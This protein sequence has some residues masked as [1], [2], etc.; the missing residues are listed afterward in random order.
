MQLFLLF[1][2][3]AFCANV[4]ALCWRW[5]SHRS[6]TAPH[7]Y[8]ASC[9]RICASTETT[10]E[11][12]PTAACERHRVAS[13]E[14]AETES[15]VGRRSKNVLFSLRLVHAWEMALER[16]DQG[17]PDI[18]D[19]GLETLMLAA[20]VNDTPG[21]AH[22]LLRM[23]PE[24]LHMTLDV[25]SIQTRCRRGM[26]LHL[27]S[28]GSICVPLVPWLPPEMHNGTRPGLL[29]L[30][31]RAGAHEVVKCLLSAGV[32]PLPSMD[33]VIGYML[34]N[35]MARTIASHVRCDHASDTVLA[36]RPARYTDILR[37]LLSNHS[38]DERRRYWMDG[39]DSPRHEALDRIN[40]SF[41]RGLAMPAYDHDNPFTVLRESVQWLFTM[42]PADT[43]L[44]DLGDV[45]PTHFA[46]DD[47]DVLLGR[48]TMERITEVI[49]MLFGARYLP[50]ER[51]RSLAALLK[52][53]VRPHG[54]QA[55]HD[56]AKHVSLYSTDARVRHIS[57]AFCGEYETHL[58]REWKLILHRLRLSTKKAQCLDPPAGSFRPCGTTAAVVGHDPLHPS[59]PLSNPLS[60]PHTVDDARDPMPGACVPPPEEPDTQPRDD[61]ATPLSPDCSWDVLPDEVVWGMF[62]HWSFSLNDLYALVH[63]R[64]QRLS[65]IAKQQWNRRMAS[66]VADD[67]KPD[68]TVA[69]DAMAEMVLVSTLVYDDIVGFL[70][71]VGARPH[72]CTARFNPDN[73]LRCDA[74]PNTLTMLVNMTCD[75]QHDSVPRLIPPMWA[76][77]LVAGNAGSLQQ[78]TVLAMA[79]RLGARRILHYLLAR[80]AYPRLMPPSIEALMA[81]VVPNALVT[82]ISAVP[83][84]RT[85]DDPATPQPATFEPA[86]YTGLLCDPYSERAMHVPRGHMYAGRAV[87]MVAV[88]QRLV[89]RF[90]RRS[91]GMREKNVYDN[92][93]TVLRE[94]AQW[95]LSNDARG[96][97][98]GEDMGDTCFCPMTDVG[99]ESYLERVVII[100]RILLNAHYSPSESAQAAVRFALNGPTEGV[101]LGRMS[102]YKL[103]WRAV[104]HATDLAVCGVAR[105][106]VRL[107][108]E[109]GFTE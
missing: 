83:Y 77:P 26:T 53:D 40:V 14:A 28:K 8:A 91:D 23:H 51:A 7:V 81:F 10:I 54:W 69:S 75:E 85:L 108:H 71:L 58:D 89:H 70:R 90:P 49:G 66:E 12:G 47:H 46:Y 25:R 102:E 57:R 16:L 3:G 61:Q 60:A 92:P 88:I 65:G 5:W 38:T 72:L 86:Y 15:A 2:M 105:T 30:A 22:L 19:R 13:A 18:P 39:D 41:V 63:V 96:F 56:R 99:Q 80:N 4:L 33:A 55:E 62:G 24:M 20:I 21:V 82:A 78:P 95:A 42:N 11:A 67:M 87:D 31:A 94:T 34:P 100:A 43:V 1:C 59:V 106:F 73:Y 6:K 101:P 68:C 74:V 79:A 98:V 27:G 45:D 76:P 52:P 107:Y 44:S 103:A 9:R 84:V 104:Q 29:A 17:V 109:Y 36:S 97:I 37:L 48:D 32:P 93:L 50:I 64:N 35:I